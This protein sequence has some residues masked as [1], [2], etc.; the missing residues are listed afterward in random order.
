[1]YHSGS[2]QY[3]E[4]RRVRFISGS[5]SSTALSCKSISAASISFSVR[6]PSPPLSDHISECESSSA[7]V[8]MWL[9]ASL[10]SSMPHATFE[11]VRLVRIGLS[12]RRFGT[13]V[14]I[15]WWRGGRD[16]FAL[17]KVGESKI[18][19]DAGDSDRFTDVHVVLRGETC[20]EK[21]Y[22]L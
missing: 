13:D 20:G 7:A 8:A 2:L 15:T 6:I 14:G 17:P 11:Y 18:E 22:S 9:A 5:F 16:L 10:V 4:P 19:G 1:M 3:A 21:R 12:Y